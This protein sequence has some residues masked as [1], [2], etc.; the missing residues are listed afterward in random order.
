[1]CRASSQMPEVDPHSPLK[2]LPFGL[3]GLSAPPRQNK[4][5]SEGFFSR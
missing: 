4:P 1:M 2:D 5:S 3:R